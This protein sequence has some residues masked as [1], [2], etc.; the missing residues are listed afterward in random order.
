M[1]IDPQLTVD[2][3]AQRELFAELLQ[4]KSSARLLRVHDKQGTGKSTLLKR[5]EYYCKYESDKAVSFVPLESFDSQTN[6]ELIRKIRQDLKPLQFAE[7]DRLR[8]ANEKQDAVEFAAPGGVSGK[9]DLRGASVTGGVQAEIATVFQGP[10]YIQNYNAAGSAWN[11]RLEKYAEERCIEAFLR[12]LKAL[13][14][15]LE[16]VLLFD[17]W[18]NNRTSSERRDWLLRTLIRPYCLDAAARPA[19]LVAVVAGQDVPDF[20]V[21]WDSKHVDSVREKPLEVWGK[22]HV[23]DFLIVQGFKDLTPKDIEYVWGLVN[24]GASLQDAID[25]TVGIQQLRKRKAG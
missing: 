13:G 7:F 24:E 17:S 5:L 9:V 10:Q 4:F 19:K 15:T 18:D 1:D 23:R 25:V 6:F 20:K 16:V 11:S 22:D 8:D 14:A 21:M 3:D 2:R 12:E